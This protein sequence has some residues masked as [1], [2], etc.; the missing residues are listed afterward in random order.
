MN[1]LHMGTPA[2]LVQIISR[3]DQNFIMTLNIS[4]INVPSWRLLS[5]SASYQIFKYQVFHSPTYWKM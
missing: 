1:I 2:F 3:F 4:E 5:L